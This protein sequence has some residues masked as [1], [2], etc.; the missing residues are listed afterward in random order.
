MPAQS[1]AGIHPVYSA[2]PPAARGGP[3]AGTRDWGL[4]IKTSSFESWQPEAGSWV[5]SPRMSL[6]RRDLLGAAAEI[7]ALAAVSRVLPSTLFAQAGRTAAAG[8]EKLIVRSVR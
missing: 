5:Q 4:E 1:H 2:G 7:G 8:K 3:S 6:T